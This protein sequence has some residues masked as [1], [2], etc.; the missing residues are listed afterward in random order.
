MIESCGDGIVNNGGT[1]ECDDGNTDPN[2]SCNNA[3]LLTAF[4]GNGFVD[5]ANGEQ[6]ETNNDCS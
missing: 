5:A 1:E 2:D 4:C 3:C 6:C